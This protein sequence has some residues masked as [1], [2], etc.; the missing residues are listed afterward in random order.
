[1]LIYIAQVALKYKLLFIYI[2]V[3]TQRQCF[4][5]KSTWADRFYLS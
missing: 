2:S 4:G 5:E 1:M 3:I